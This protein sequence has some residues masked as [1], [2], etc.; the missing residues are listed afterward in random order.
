MTRRNL[1]PPKLSV[2]S[3]PGAGPANDVDALGPDDLA[4]WQR[5][6]SLLPEV[7]R[8]LLVSVAQTVQTLATAP[9]RRRSSVR[10]PEPAE[11]LDPA[12]VAQAEALLRPFAGGMR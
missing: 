5:A 1:I 12:A 3:T 2:N 7:H 6:W 10:A 9:R 8:R 4:A 11:V